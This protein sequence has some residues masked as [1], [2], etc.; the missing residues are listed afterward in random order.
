MKL[1]EVLAAGAVSAG[2]LALL[3]KAHKEEQAKK[4]EN[5]RRMNT[6]CDF[7]GP[8]TEKEFQAIVHSAAKTIRRLKVLEID[9]P[10]VKCSVRS[11]SGIS[12]WE[13]T[14]D[15]N[16]YGEITGNCWTDTENED[17]RIPSV[18][19]ERIQDE[20]DAFM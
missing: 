4:E 7:D 12:T 9:G 10:V 20:L 19:R 14:L 6:P 3:N 1:L 11:T 5:S 13:F 2:L 16:D 17:S 8:I 18:L 15:F